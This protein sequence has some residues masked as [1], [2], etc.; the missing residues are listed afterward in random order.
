MLQLHYYITLTLFDS[1]GRSTYSNLEK[2]GTP[3]DKISQCVILK[4]LR[5]VVH[6][7]WFLTRNGLI[8]SVELQLPVHLQWGRPPKQDAEITKRKQMNKNLAS[9][10]SG[11]TEQ[12]VVSLS[13]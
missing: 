4:E 13:S 5:A 3:R 12:S 10:S 1:K 6:H 2:V 11:V 9:Y 7:N 8:K